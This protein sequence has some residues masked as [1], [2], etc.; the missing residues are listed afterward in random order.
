MEKAID[1]EGLAGL[2]DFFFFPKIFELIMTYVPDL[3]NASL[4]SPMV[5][6]CVRRMM[7]PGSHRV[8]RREGLRLLLLWMKFGFREDT[9]HLFIS[10]VDL[11]QFNAD[12]SIKLTVSEFPSSGH[13]LVRSNLSLI[14]QAEEMFEDILHMVTYD[15][16]ANRACIQA[17]YK[18]FRRAYLAVLYPNVF[19]EYKLLRQE[20]GTYDGGPGSR[21]ILIRFRW[22][23]SGLPAAAAGDP[24]PVPDCLAAPGELRQPPPDLVLHL[25]GHPAFLP[26][27]L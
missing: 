5:V 15:Q 14:K 4:D 1:R 9:R 7:M 21:S 20:S 13:P 6:N 12:A 26:G 10:C 19:R 24:G 23:H 11:T 17:I 16:D 2:A 3:L 25:C 27:G 22:L 8:L 18:E